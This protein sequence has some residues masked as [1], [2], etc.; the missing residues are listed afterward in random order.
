MKRHLP[1]RF[2]LFLASLCLSFASHSENNDFS[3]NA[4]LQTFIQE[5]SEEHEFDRD[6]LQKLFDDARQHQSILDAISRP[7]ESKPWHKYRPIF[8]TPERTNGGVRFWRENQDTLQRAEEKYGVPPQIITAIIGVETRYGR[9]AGRY[10]VLDALATLAFAYPPR[11]SFFRKE[12]KE[13][14]LM[15]REEDLDPL[16]QKGSY[17]GAMGMP[18]FISS[19]FRNYAIDFDGDGKRDLWDNPDDV[20]GSVANYFHEHRWKPGQPIA[21][22]VKVHG[23]KYRS[24]I[25]DNLRA[26][27]SQQELLDNG[28]ILPRDIPRD[29]KGTLIEL[30]TEEGPEYWVTWHNFYVISRYNHSALYSMAVYQLSE[31]IAT[32]RN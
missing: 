31:L 2:T 9:H 28:V 19:S 21:H 12:L 23:K 25:S 14:L 20:I 13:Y 22:K 6:R 26:R 16:E 30:E 11:S 1:L 3:G 29:I 8:V 27:Y 10:R 5:M 7:A 24:L 32:A 4:E 18:Q 17:A 15:T